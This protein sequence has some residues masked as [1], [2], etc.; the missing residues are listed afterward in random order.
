MSEV[1]EARA[2]FEKSPQEQ[3]RIA[4]NVGNFSVALFT[5][6]HPS[7]ARNVNLIGTGT[8]VSVGNQDY[9]L[10]AA[11][12]WHGG[13]QKHE[14]VGV[15]LTE[16]LDH[17]FPIR[18]DTIVECGLP[19]TK[20]DEWGPDV[21]LLRIPGEHVGKIKAFRNFY[22][23]DI[24]RKKVEGDHLEGRILVGTPGV[25]AKGIGKVQQVEINSFYVQSDAKFY[26]R[27]GFDYIDFEMDTTREG[28]MK[29][30]RGVSGGGVWEVQIFP[31]KREGTFDSTET[32]V[33]VAFYQLG[34][35]NSHQTV[36]CHGPQTIQ[37]VVE[38][39]RV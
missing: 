17:Y 34:L 11:H 35:K 9:I 38:C 31:A 24:Q 21:I 13:L 25:L 14:A 18:T 37:A 28:V 32:L 2:A 23:L 26:G 16:D 30:F 15:T 27:E 1:D 4:R 10:T 39:V 36:R 7:G 12:V 29:D 19:G 6:D 33:G 8:L 3:E 22:R 5:V 20:A